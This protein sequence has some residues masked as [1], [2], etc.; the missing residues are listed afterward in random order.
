MV[1]A[2]LGFSIVAC[3]IIPQFY[4]P[5]SDL[6]IS[7]STQETLRDLTWLLVKTGGAIGVGCL[8]LFVVTVIYVLLTKII[9]HIVARYDFSPTVKAFVKKYRAAEKACLE[10]DNGD[11]TPKS[12]RSRLIEIL[13]DLI[14]SVCL[15]FNDAILNRSEGTTIVE[16][17]KIVAVDDLLIFAIVILVCAASKK[18]SD[19]TEARRAKG[20]QDRLENDEELK[21]GVSKQEI[22]PEHKSEQ[23]LNDISDAK[24]N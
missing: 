11:D 3:S 16:S 19:I 10:E 8:F 1:F 21:I 18:I 9:Y 4:Y 7:D 17:A 5:F 23:E 13:I 24:K 14:V 15:L 12:L 2:K 22:V 20:E 6:P